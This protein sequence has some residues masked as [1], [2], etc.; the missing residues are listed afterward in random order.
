MIDPSLIAEEFRR[1]LA[2]RVKA[3]PEPLT[4]VGFLATDSAPSLTYASYTKI[5]CDDVGIRFEMR[6]VNRHE[7]EGAIEAANVD[8]KVHGIIVYYPIFTV[9]RD[10]YV[11]DLVDPRK[12]I[13]G[14]HSFWARKLYHNERHVDGDPA[15]KSILPCTPLAVIKLIA[16]GGVAPKGKSITIFNRSEVVGRPLAAMLANDG[17][18]VH[19]FDVDGPLLFKYGLEEDT[20]ITREAALAQADIVITGVPSRSFPLVQAAEIRPGALCINFSTLKNFAPEI[21]E[22]A[23]TFVPRVGPMTVA[24]ALRNT[25]RLYENYHRKGR[26]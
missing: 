19:S 10:R 18:T 2:V 1:D 3:L 26:A 24:M 20:K 9:E 7:I 8:P 5:G 12:D 17:A 23:S 11:K 21:L 6:N 25:L 14:L 15:K 22:K 16:A 4:L 13:E